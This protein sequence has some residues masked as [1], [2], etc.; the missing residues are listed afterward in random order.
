MDWS[1]KGRTIKERLRSYPLSRGCDGNGAEVTGE[2]G[3]GRDWIVRE[4]KGFA[5][6]LHK[7]VAWSVL[8]CR[9][10]D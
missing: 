6:I 5:L 2:E 4:R 10:E 9:R 3:T 8:E 7:G 1:V